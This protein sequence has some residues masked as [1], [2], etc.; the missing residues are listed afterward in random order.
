MLGM[1]VSREV[2]YMFIFE[3]ICDMNVRVL[4][5]L[6]EFVSYQCTLTC[7]VFFLRYIEC[8]KRFSGAWIVLLTFAVLDPYYKCDDLLKPSFLVTIKHL[9]A[10]LPGNSFSWINECCFCLYLSV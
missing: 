1:L 2:R 7:F 5:T 6:L 10:Y 4:C 3:N 9:F 8:F